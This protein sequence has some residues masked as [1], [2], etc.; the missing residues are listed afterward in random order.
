MGID[1]DMTFQYNTHTLYHLPAICIGVNPALFSSEAEAP[2]SN[3][4]LT[5]SKCPPSVAMCNGV[6]SVTL[7]REFNTTFKSCDI[8]SWMTDKDP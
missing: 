5:T 2:L 8:N 7:F 4:F 3:N 6:E 1:F